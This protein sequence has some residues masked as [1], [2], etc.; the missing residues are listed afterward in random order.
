MAASSAVL[1][2]IPRGRRYCN[3]ETI[4]SM[5]AQ[6]AMNARSCLMNATIHNAA[7]FAATLLTFVLANGGSF[8]QTPR[9]LTLPTFV[10][11]NPDGSVGTGGLILSSDVLHAL[12]EM[13]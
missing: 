4:M 6:P 1:G 10:Y 11:V 5:H 8:A 3:C 13:E 9:N 2:A 7:F 12:A